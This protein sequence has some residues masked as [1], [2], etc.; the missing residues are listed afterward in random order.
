MAA[1]LNFL[2]LIRRIKLLFFDSFIINTSS[3]LRDVLL[4]DIHFTHGKNKSVHIRLSAA[5]DNKPENDGS[6]FLW[7]SPVDPELGFAPV[8]SLANS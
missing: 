3:D 8:Q 7:S 5:R 6:V 2:D 1:I 4:T